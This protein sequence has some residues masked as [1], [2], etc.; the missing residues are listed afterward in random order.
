KVQGGLQNALDVF[1]EVVDLGLPAFKS[2]EFLFKDPL[3]GFHDPFLD[4]AS[5]HSEHAGNQKVADPQQRKFEALFQNV[6]DSPPWEGN[7]VEKIR[8]SLLDLLQQV[9]I[10]GTRKELCDLDERTTEDVTKRSE[11]FGRPARPVLQ[12]AEQFSKIVRVDFLVLRLVAAA[13]DVD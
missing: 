9:P 4:R 13:D 11:N 6:A 12:P 7:L 8:R 2:L 10:A 1:H 3:Q 5:H